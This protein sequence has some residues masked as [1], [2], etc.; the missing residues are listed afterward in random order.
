MSKEERYMRPLHVA[1]VNLGVFVMAGAAVLTFVLALVRLVGAVLFVS[2]LAANG[3]DRLLAA[4]DIRPQP[5]VLMLVQV[6][7]ATILAVIF[8]T[9]AF[10]LRSV[11]L[12]KR[13]AVLA[14]DIRDLDE[15]K[16]YLIG[17]VVT[18]MST[19][20]LEFLLGR[21][22]EAGQALSA[23]IG[24]AAVILALSAYTIVLRR[25]GSGPGSHRE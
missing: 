16:T 17:L 19:R 8:L 3:A 15:L 22:S 24:T 25:Y 20:Y 13:Y 2:G 7:D 18:L 14:F 6:V 10:G 21:E 1:G 12:G 5:V 4:F 9:F 23:G 11:F